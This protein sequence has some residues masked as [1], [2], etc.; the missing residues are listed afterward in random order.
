MTDSV[1][2]E[3][4][5][6]RVLE[7]RIFGWQLVVRRCEAV[8]RQFAIYAKLRDRTYAAVAKCK[9]I[10]DLSVRREALIYVRRRLKRLGTIR[11]LVYDKWQAIL[12]L[13]IALLEAK[14]EQCEQG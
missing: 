6:A 4:M 14:L 2:M 9:T 5:V 12:S 3:H 8:L 7:A 13:E 1:I 10:A 11:T